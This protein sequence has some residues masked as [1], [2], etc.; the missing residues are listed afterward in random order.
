MY[1]RYTALFALRNNG[2]D[3]AVT[4]IIDSLSSKSALLKHEVCFALTFLFQHNDKDCIFF[5]YF[6]NIF[7][8]SIIVN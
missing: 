8:I 1:E 2:N 4:A 3:E 7:F 5:K 6:F